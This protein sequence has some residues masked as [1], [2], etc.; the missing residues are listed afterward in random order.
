M[1]RHLLGLVLAMAAL[2]A[3]AEVS[4]TRLPGGGTELFFEP[5]AT[6]PWARVRPDV[7][8][9]T[10]LNPQGDA[11][12]DGWPSFAQRADGLPSVAYATAGDAG[13][14]WLAWHDG[15]N[16]Q[17]ARNVSDRAGA[18]F[19]PSVVLDGWNN[20]FIAWNNTR[21]SRVSVMLAGVR[22]DGTDQTGVLELTARQRDGRK[23]SLAAFGDDVYVAYED[24][25]N[26]ND[27]VPY[28]AIDRVMPDRDP[29]RSLHCS[30][31]NTP[32][33][34]RSATIRTALTDRALHGEPL[35]NVE[36]GELWITWIDSRTRVGWVELTGPGTFSE[37]A[38][39]PYDPNLGPE[40][41]L[42]DIRNQVLAP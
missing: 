7:S 2:P 13:D 36:D 18:D 25:A 26:G 24:Q 5:A 32:D 21:G 3:A 17:S 23:P 27:D 14:V 29:D 40:G 9:T 35:V 20:R 28:I 15:T 8:G 41:T 10:L 31:E 30:G 6:G 1:R 34:S 37:P 16:W 12:A 4:V 11:R 19:A 33:L 38:Y 22:N 39:R 42:E